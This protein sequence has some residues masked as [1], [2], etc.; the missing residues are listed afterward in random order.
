MFFREHIIVTKD[1]GFFCNQFNKI[2]VAAPSNFCLGVFCCQKEPTIGNFRA[3]NSPVYVE[4]LK[5][6]ELS[7]RSQKALPVKYLE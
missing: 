2:Q 6:W 7:F 5:F 1:F 4:L 3:G